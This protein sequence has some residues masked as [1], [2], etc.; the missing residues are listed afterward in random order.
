MKRLGFGTLIAALVLLAGC[1]ALNLGGAN[2]TLKELAPKTL[3]VDLKG[4]DEAI[5]VTGPEV[6]A[7]FRIDGPSPGVTVTEVVLYFLDPSGKEISG[8]EQH[9][10]ANK[11]I[12]RADSN[13]SVEDSYT[14]GADYKP[15]AQYWLGQAILAAEQAQAIPYKGWSVRI[16][17]KLKDD[18]G[19][20]YTFE[21]ELPISVDVTGVPLTAPPQVE[22]VNP[23]DNATLSGEVVLEVRA[24]DNYRVNEVV[25]YAGGNRLGKGTLAADDQTY[26]LTWDTTGYPDGAVKL[27]AR[28]YDAAGNVGSAA[29]TVTVANADEEAPSVE[30]VK[31]ADGAVLSGVV[32][33]EVS[34]R[35]NVAVQRVAFYAGENLLGE[36]TDGSDGYTLDWDTT[37]YPDGAVKLEARAYDAAGNV[38]SAA[39]TVT[40]AND[41]HIQWLKVGESNPAQNLRIAGLV[42]LEAEV[43]APRG[44][45]KVEF[46]LRGGAGEV[47][48][49]DGVEDS[50]VYKGEF[51]T[52]RIGAGPYEL[53][54][55]VTDRGGYT[56]ESTLSVEVVD[57]FVITNPQDGD[58]VGPGANRT[59]V[60]VTVGLNGTLL[61]E[62]GEIDRVEIYLN[63]KFIAEANKIES[64]NDVAYIYAWDTSVDI[65]DPDPANPPIHD[66]QKGGDRIL[67]AKIYTTNGEYLTPGVQVNFRP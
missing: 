52:D 15:F 64:S 57:P 54:A 42:K 6:S 16:E 1:S 43:D 40:F 46:L 44:V 5:E 25:F 65:P 14:F 62:L 4:T 58:E 50:G 47:K 38:G 17:F 37:G 56:A 35:D 30:W 66:A 39:I 24:R 3:N 49:A 67:T 19:G 53:V 10:K 36:D 41:P 9:I 7:V 45:E 18:N 63:G 59:I 12:P 21:Q 60:S 55:K 31:P 8:L 61:G 28:A 51:K 34:A 29:V 23:K 32:T 48:V 26:R 20:R 2:V 33:L 13:V 11:H 27:E 22:W